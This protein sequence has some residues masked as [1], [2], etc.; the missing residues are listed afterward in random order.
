LRIGRD[1]PVMARILYIEDNLF[2]RI[3]VRRVLQAAGIDVLE[4]DSPLSGISLACKTRPDLILMD[5][6]MP[7]VDGL[8][9]AR[10]LRQNPALTGIPIV[11]LTANVMPADRDRALQVCDGFIPKPIDVDRFPAEVQRYFRKEQPSSCPQP[12]MSAT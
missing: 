12:E 1:T 10:Q 11:A 4:A 7:E 5:L 9:V 2:N 3:L 8:T 6:S